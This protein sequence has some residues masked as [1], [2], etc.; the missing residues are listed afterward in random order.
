MTLILLSLAAHRLWAIWHGAEIARPFRERIV[1]RGGKIG[2]LAS[3]EFCTSVWAGLL[4]T[5]FW[6][7]IS[8]LEVPIYALAAGVG[9]AVVQKTFDLMEF[10]TA[11]PRVVGMAL[12]VRNGSPESSSARIPVP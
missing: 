8:W 1:R 11:Y 10:I 3:C 2:Y 7:W 6:P 9:V 12:S 5:L 4:A